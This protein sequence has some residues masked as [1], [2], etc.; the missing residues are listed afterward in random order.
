MLINELLNIRVI[1][2]L[3]KQI[4][5]I[6]FGLISNSFTLGEIIFSSTALFSNSDIQLKPMGY[7]LIMSFHFHF[8]TFFQVTSKNVNAYL[9]IGKFSLV[10][11][12]FDRNKKIPVKQ[13]EEWPI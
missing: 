11:K 1:R 4:M 12:C 8:F 3:I 2:Y 7:L 5:H 13:Q 9:V 6:L 10:C